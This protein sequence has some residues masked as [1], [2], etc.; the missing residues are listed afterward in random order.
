[1]DDPRL[2]GT[3]EPI[4][5]ALGKQVKLQKRALIRLGWLVDEDAEETD[6]D[7]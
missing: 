3:L 7:E 2:A 1:M 6:V 4:A 5:R